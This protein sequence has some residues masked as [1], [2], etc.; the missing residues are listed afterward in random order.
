MSRSSFERPVRV[1]AIEVTTGRPGGDDKLEAGDL[2]ISADGKKFTAV[3]KFKD[4]AA[5]AKLP[6][7]KEIAAVRVHP[8]DGLKHPLTIREFGIHSSPGCTTFKN[9]IEVFVDVSDA[10]EMKDWAEKCARV[11]ERTYPM[12][13]EQL[14]SDHFQPAH[15]VHMTLKRDYRGVAATGGTHIVGAVKWFKEHPEDVGA[16]VHETVHVVQAY[17]SRG[18]PGWLVEGIADYV[19]FFKYEPGNLGRINPDR[20]HYNGSYRVTAAFLAYLVDKHD[21]QI[22]RKLNA[23]MRA[24]KYNDQ[25]FKDYTG[26]TLEELDDAW[27]ATLKR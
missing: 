22:V 24:G 10:P 23:A 25:L 9:P 7:G 13:V 27:R 17:H 20:S 21:P 5:S 2:E 16:M 15:E 26:K 18:N 6:D 3:A 12:I 1:K 4:G 19:R 8:A 11:C 14:A